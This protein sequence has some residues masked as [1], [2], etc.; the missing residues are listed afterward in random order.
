MANSLTGLTGNLAE[1]LHTKV[2]AKIVSPALKI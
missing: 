1:S 2:N